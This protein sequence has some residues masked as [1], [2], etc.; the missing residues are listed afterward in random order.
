[1]PFLPPRQVNLIA[2]T[3][4]GA[5]PLDTGLSHA[6]ALAVGA[7]DLGESLRLHGTS[8]VVAFGRQDVLASGYAEAVRAARGLGFEAVERLAGG[9]AAV[10]HTGTLAFSWAVPAL[11][12]RAGV[13]ERFERIAQVMV[14]AIRQLG[15]DA[16]IGEVPGEYCPGAFSVNIGGVTKV[17]GVGQRLVRGAAHVGGVVVVHE[18]DRL[19]TVLTPVYRALGLDWRPETAGA[20]DDVLSGVTLDAVRTAI[21]DQ[22]ADRAEIV[23]HPLPIEVTEMGRRLSETHRP[24]VTSV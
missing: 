3:T 15:A 13:H 2:D 12:P 14:D 20:L 17:M 16:R 24:S 6:V 10:F 19:R 5:G 23:S 21:L 8:D 9:R 1:M 18:S 7:G 22:V 11:D 4:D